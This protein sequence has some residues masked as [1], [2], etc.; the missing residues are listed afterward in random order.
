MAYIALQFCYFY[1]EH[2]AF[3]FSFNI[4]QWLKWLKNNILT[5][6]SELL[7]SPK[8]FWLILSPDEHSGQI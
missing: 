7:V 5:F 4:M 6:F 3:N 2:N 8:F 1:I